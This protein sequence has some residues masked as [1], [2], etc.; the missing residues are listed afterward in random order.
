MSACG[1]VLLAGLAV[2]SAGDWGTGLVPRR[3]SYGAMVYLSV[4]LGDQIAG[5]VVIMA[6]FAIA[7]RF[8]GPSRPRA[9]R[10]LRLHGAAGLIRGRPRPRRPGARPRVSSCLRP[11]VR[12]AHDKDANLWAMMRALC[13]LSTLAIIASTIPVATLRSCSALLCSA[14]R[15]AERRVRTQAP[16]IPGPVWVTIDPADHRQVVCSAVSIRH[17]ADRKR[18]F[19]R[20]DRERFRLRA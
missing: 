20:P 12:Y 9:S 1:A 14:L 13:G 10:L 2:E 18:R 5:V 15:C 11:L 3:S 16:S 8:P 7:R 19:R 6:L 17:S 4:V